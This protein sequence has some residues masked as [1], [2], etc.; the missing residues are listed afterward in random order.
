ME[1]TM[2]IDRGWGIAEIEV[3]FKKICHV[4][5]CQRVAIR[6]LG[7]SEC[8]WGLEAEDGKAPREEVHYKVILGSKT[9]ELDTS[10]PLSSATTVTRLFRLS[11]AA[12]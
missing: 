3:H 8:D 6:Q 1:D 7:E 2:E 4:L 5:E 9:H 11:L 12:I 10:F